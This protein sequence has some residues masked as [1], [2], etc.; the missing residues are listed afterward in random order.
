MN[1]M[2]P[3]NSLSQRLLVIGASC[4]LFQSVQASTLFTE[5][6]DYSTPGNLGGNVNPGSGYTWGPGNNNLTIGSGN[7]TYPG[8]ADLGGNEL[9]VNWGSAGSVTNGFANVTSGT[10]F[11]SFLLDVTTAPSGNNY[12]TSLNPGTST[13]NGSSDALTMYFATI[14][15][16][17][18]YRLGVRTAGAST[19]NTPSGSP[20]SLGTTYLVVLEYDFSS[21]IASL[22]LNPTPGDP[23]PAA[24]V[25][26]TGNGSVTGI[27]DVGFKSQS[28]TGAMLVDNLRI[29][30]TWNDVVPEPTSIALF[31]LAAV[32]LIVRHRRTRS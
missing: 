13:P 15:G 20:F 26:A 6:F 29:G 14:T 28:G 23:M 32:G 30:T 11:Y 12:L 5:G 24:T 7:L 10:I 4:F 16:G 18:G 2:N 31:G 27:D 21:S 19:V 25:F 9:S 1:S 3:Y 8:I 22:Y 17:G